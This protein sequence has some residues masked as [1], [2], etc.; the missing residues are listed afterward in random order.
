MW[1]KLL[2]CSAAACFAGFAASACSDSESPKPAVV[3][4]SAPGTKRVAPPMP[5]AGSLADCKPWE[6]PGFKDP[7]WLPPAPLG[8]PACA[9]GVVG[10]MVECLL[11]TP[12][13]EKICDATVNAAEN[14]DCFDCLFTDKTTVKAL[15]PLVID[16]G[17]VVLNVGGCIAAS[18]GETTK[19]GCGA[20]Y[21][22][23][24]LCEDQAC[25]PNCSS[26]GEGAE[27][28][29]E[30]CKDMAASG[31]CEPYSTPAKCAEP[32][33]APGGVAAACAV[34]TKEFTEAAIA[35]G[36]LFCT[37]AGDAGSDA[38]D[39]SDAPEGG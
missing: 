34:D 17:Y 38:S 26:E 30:A 33:L 25:A 11:G 7:D 3:D 16:N 12:A 10:L 31:V 21:A 19:T 18:T 13:D 36:I 15:G 28:A 23:G 6:L 24:A 5:D 32:L 2:A 22:A 35:L 39:A 8:K 1:T 4:A 27:A 29:Y 9:P 37:G 20:R 14:G